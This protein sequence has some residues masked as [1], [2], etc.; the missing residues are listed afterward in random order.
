MLLAKVHAV[1]W[2]S[3][4]FPQ[5]IQRRSRHLRLASRELAQHN[6]LTTNVGNADAGEGRKPLGTKP[7]LIA[8]PI[9]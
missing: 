1:G 4:V 7:D 8:G 5:W 9:H 6:E 2:T 3:G